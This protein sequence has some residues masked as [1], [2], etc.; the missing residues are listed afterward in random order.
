MSYAS[1]TNVTIERSQEQIKSTLRRY[2]ADEFAVMERRDLACIGFVFEGLAIQITVPLPD[3]DASEFRTTDTGRD[4]TDSAALKA[5]EQ[6]TKARW[7]S[8]LLAIKAKLE[9]VEVGISTLEKEF[10]PFIVMGDGRTLGDHLLPRLQEAARL[11]Q[12]PSQLALPAHTSIQD[13]Q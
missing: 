1:G 12:M 10:M 13:T 11:G 8:L 5:W 7:R 3:R 9:A 4:R 2:G 6:A